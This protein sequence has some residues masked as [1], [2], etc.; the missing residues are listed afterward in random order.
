MNRQVYYKERLGETSTTST[1]IYDLATSLSFLPDAS[2]DYILLF[3]C[4]SK[5]STASDNTDVTAD[6]DTLASVVILNTITA[7]D[8]ANYVSHGGIVSFSADATP[9]EETIGINYRASGSGTASIRDVRV[10]AIKKT[11]S[12]FYVEGDGVDTS[13]TDPQEAASLTITT[14]G[15][16]MVFAWAEVVHNATT[17]SAA[18]KLSHNSTDY[19]LSLFRPG[20]TSDRRPWF[21]FKQI[22]AAAND[23]LKIYAYNLTADSTIAFPANI[24]ALRLDTLVDS[25]YAESLDKSFN[26]TT[27]YADKVTMTETTLKNQ[28]LLAFNANCDQSTNTN[29]VEA[30]GV[31]NSTDIN[32]AFIAEPWLG[33]GNDDYSFAVV[34]YEDLEA[35][36]QT[37][38]VQWRRAGAVSTAGIESAA[39]FVGQMRGQPSVK[40]LGKTLIKG[41]TLIK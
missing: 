39:I 23:T 20:D 5:I 30:K 4:L 18:I 14:A 35:A 38:K 1:G 37:W 7:H 22:T 10:M 32:A 27:T 3:T 6:I 29:S 16:Y 8:G 41:E 26:S 9:V 31:Q 15:D 25:F 33:S 24:F 34:S 40:I 12:D 36:S 2:S 17:S 13:S 19:N 11:A 21:A 28:F